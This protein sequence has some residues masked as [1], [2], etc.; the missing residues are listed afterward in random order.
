M[1]QMNAD[2]LTKE[3]FKN[4]EWNPNRQND[5]DPQRPNLKSITNED[6]HRSRYSDHKFI[7]DKLRKGKT[8]EKDRNNMVRREVRR[9]HKRMKVIW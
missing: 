4:Q 2:R 9:P 6:T 7:N 3:L 5:R 8:N 1:K